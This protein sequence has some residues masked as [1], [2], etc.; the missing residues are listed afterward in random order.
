MVYSFFLACA[1]VSILMMCYKLNGHGQREVALSSGAKI[2][3]RLWK[4]Q[5][6]RFFLVIEG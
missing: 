1:S 2:W 5:P 6:A 4:L 3:L